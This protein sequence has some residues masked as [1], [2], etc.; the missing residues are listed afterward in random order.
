MIWSVAAVRP[1]L[2]LGVHAGEVITIEPKPGRCVIQVLGPEARQ[3]PSDLDALC[4]GVNAG[5]LVPLTTSEM[6]AL[7]THHNRRAHLHLVKGGIA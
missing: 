5:A 7:I 3:L 6:D 4:Q 1:F 2:P